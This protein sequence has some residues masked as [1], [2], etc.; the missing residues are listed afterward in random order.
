MSEQ[1]SARTVNYPNP[2]N[3]SQCHN[4]GPNVVKES[5]ARVKSRLAVSDLG[6]LDED[7]SVIIT[8]LERHHDG[9]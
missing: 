8:A 5:V 6:G 2:D 3:C 9:S 4:I 7:V 1:D